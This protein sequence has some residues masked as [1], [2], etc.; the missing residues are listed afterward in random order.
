MLQEVVTGESPADQRTGNADVIDGDSLDVAEVRVR[1]YG[2]DAPEA[3]QLCRR[4]GQSWACG[5]EA[6]KA[7]VSAIA[8]R[9]W[10]TSST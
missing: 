7:L 6:G 3:G 9:Y 10:R 8:G 2:I 1:L 5:A 4:G